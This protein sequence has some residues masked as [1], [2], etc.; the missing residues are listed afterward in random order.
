MKK[1]K[2]FILV[3]SLIAAMFLTFVAIDSTTNLTNTVQ[4]SSV[5]FPKNM[6]GHWKSKP[7]YTWQKK[8]INKWM[9]IPAM[10]MKVTAKKATWHF[11]GYLPKGMGYNHKKY[12]LRMSNS[13]GILKGHGPFGQTNSFEIRGKKLILFYQGGG[14]IT[15]NKAR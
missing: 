2:K 10:D 3:L 5:S 9:A 15:F 13:N 4:A 14:M 12:V 7:T 8:H 11:V 1:T 6:R